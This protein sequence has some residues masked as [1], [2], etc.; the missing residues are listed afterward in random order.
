MSTNQNQNAA[1]L[2]DAVTK[3]TAAVA[4]ESAEASAVIQ[5]LA[6]VPGQI[7]AAVA[8]DAAANAIDPAQLTALSALTD[9]IKKDA[10]N[11]NTA[12]Q[13]APQPTPAPAPPAAT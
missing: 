3:L 2:A 5:Y 9:S 11:M 12:L 13:A 6:T 4:D 8:A 10:T 7:A 1:I